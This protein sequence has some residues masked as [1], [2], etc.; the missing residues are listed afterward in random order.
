MKTIIIGGVA[1]G[2]SAAAKLRRTSE[3]E[4]IVIYESG[5]YISYSTCGMPYLIGREDVNLQNLTPR[6]PQWFLERYNINI[7]INHEVLEITPDNK[8]IQVKDLQTS[9][10]F[11]DYYDTL[12]LAT[13]SKASLPPIE[14]LALSHVFTIK[15]MDDTIKLQK[16]LSNHNIENALIMGAGFIGIEILDNLLQKGIRTSVIEAGKQLMPP[17]DD[18]MSIWLEDYLTKKGISYHLDSKVTRIDKNKVTLSNNRILPA[19][20]VVIA[21]GITPEVSLANAIGIKLG[22]TGAILVDDNMNTSHKS[23]KAIGDCTEI[24]S[25]IDHQALYRPMGSTANKMGRISTGL[26]YAQY[27]LNFRGVLGTGIMQFKELTIGFT[28]YSEKLARDFGYDVEIIHNIKENQ[29]KYLPESREMIIKGVAD[30]KT[31]RLL[32][33]QLIGERG[34]DK[35]LD[36]FATAISFKA[37]VEDLFHLDLSY[38]PPYSTTKD[39][40]H[41]TGMILA[42]AIYDYRKIITPSTLIGHEEEYL[43]IDVRSPKDYEKGHISQAINI[44]LAKLRS[45]LTSLNPK[46]EIITHCNKGVTG[47]AAQNILI[48]NGFD[49]VYNLSGGYKNYSLYSKYRSNRN[50]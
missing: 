33:A 17:L 22:K 7:K 5:Q 30:R 35:R 19:D 9:Q 46:K 13:G 11:T 2:T 26:L 47:N 24:W 40:V 42:N 41:Y 37:K 25:S 43:I 20:L 23:I 6:D 4:D 8:S 18:D 1:A 39:P 45:Q 31:G 3:T 29:S 21:V 16:Y 44:P 48:N 14:G 32:G 50:D 38:A 27:P 34:V 10:I 28:G 15:N 49:K 36:V 12:I